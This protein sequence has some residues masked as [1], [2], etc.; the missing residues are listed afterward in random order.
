MRL[1]FWLLPGLAAINPSCTRDGEVVNVYSARHYEVDGR[2]LARFT[3]ETGIRVNLVGADSDQL[4]TRLRME[5]E[6]TRADVLITADAS[7]LIM[8]K[9][10][11]LLQK[12]DSETVRSAVPRHLRDGDMYWTGLSKRVRLFVYDPERVDPGELAGYEGLTD[13][14]WE[15]S[16]LVRSSA[17]HYNQTLLA[18]VIHEHG[19][20]GALAWAQGIAANMAQEPR[21]NDRD[22][23]KFIAA[24]LGD[25][26]IV[27]SYYMGLM[28][29]S[30]N[31]EER[32]VAE[33]MRV[34]FPNQ[35]GRGS[36]INI[37]GAALT[38]AAANK[39]NGIRLIEFLL[40]REA[41]EQIAS[42][43]YEYPVLPGAGWPDLLHE[44]G[45]YKEDT[46]SLEQ[47][48]RYR[49]QSIMIFNRAGWR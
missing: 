45:T 47:L 15:G 30:Q 19:E 21:G 36:H 20:D 48:G 46:V 42:E 39:E 29:Y 35:S 22:Q 5:G 34:F 13:D 9:E 37:S 14:K 3:E 49:E 17:S 44:W 26:A 23:V 12:I 2:L 40:A 27:N 24:G 43:N 28:H 25:V 32:R 7:R 16:I 4:V 31:D 8:A 18:S 10:L 1:F 6:R 41:Q 38:A 11:G 33:Q